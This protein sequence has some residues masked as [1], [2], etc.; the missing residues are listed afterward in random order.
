[1]QNIS[2]IKTL[3]LTKINFKDFL[4]F[5]EYL[6]FI[7][8]YLVLFIIKKVPNNQKIHFSIHKT[9]ISI[10]WRV[11]YRFPPNIKASVNQD[12][13]IGNF[14][15]FINQTPIL[16]IGFFTNSLNSSTKIY[17]CY[18]LQFRPISVELTPIVQIIIFSCNL[19][20]DCYY[21]FL[22]H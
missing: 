1:M 15:K 10:F 7:L 6:F 3:I 18:R 8:F 19:S 20:F 17:M 5:F 12:P 13:Y 11:Y 22:N 4:I 9:P 14:F 16:L 21:N 2:N